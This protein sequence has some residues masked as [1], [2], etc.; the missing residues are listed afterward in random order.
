M[1][2]WF[3]HNHQNLPF[4][5]WLIILN[6]KFLKYFIKFVWR[7]WLWLFAFAILGGSWTSSEGSLHLLVSHLS[8]YNVHSFNSFIYFI[9]AYYLARS[10]SHHIPFFNSCAY[11][12]GTCILIYPVAYGFI[13]PYILFFL[14][15]FLCP[16]LIYV[17]FLYF[18]PYFLS[19]NVLYCPLSCGFVLCLFVLLI[20]DLPCD[21]LFCPMPY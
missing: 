1:P 11:Y 14:C 6:Y 18:E 16:I 3:L 5:L 2:A 12:F 9:S 17:L 21:L 13:Q 15:P 20:T 7:W 8:T 19:C 4:L 10:L